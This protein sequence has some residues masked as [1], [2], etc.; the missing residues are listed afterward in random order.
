[1]T[2]GLHKLAGAPSSGQV[3]IIIIFSAAKPVKANFRRIDSG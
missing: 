2:S 3:Y 1:M